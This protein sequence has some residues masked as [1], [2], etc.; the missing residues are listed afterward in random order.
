MKTIMNKAAIAALAV[1]SVAMASC[2]VQKQKMAAMDKLNGEWTI[3]EVDG[4]KVRP[5]GGQAPFIGF[6]IAGGRVYGY[7]GCNRI[8]SAI[9]KKSGRLDLSR[10][11]ST[12]MACPDME[13]ESKILA[14]LTK[15][16]GASESADGSIAL[17]DGKGRTVGRL[18]RRFTAAG[19]AS[20][21]GS[22]NIVAVYGEPV[23]GNG[24]N[25][26]ALTFDT[27][28]GRLGG[29]TGCNRIM[30]GITRTPGKADG[31]SFGGVGTT[32]MACPDMTTERAI[33][34]ALAS[35]KAFGQL[36]GGNIALL[37]EGRM[38]AV[39]LEKAAE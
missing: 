26:P 23:K 16:E 31:I 37:D 39:E 22:W 1:C 14:A 9:D 25:T 27:K 6:D 29:S 8:M 11:G 19:F 4:S 5:T 15:A 18:V 7:T 24:D 30:G 20:L 3:E 2:A 33:T 13:T 17:T 35:V 10:M 21:E 38:I 12:M 34:D 36:P 28:A 32:R